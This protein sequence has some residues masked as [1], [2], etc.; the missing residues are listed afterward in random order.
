[1]YLSQRYWVTLY[2]ILYISQLF[3]YHIL[4]RR[5][6]DFTKHLIFVDLVT[7]LEIF[8]LLDN[9]RPLSLTIDGRSSHLRISSS[10]N[11]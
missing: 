6:K 3:Y 4:E 1:M 8:V 11:F 7:I 9:S 5:T 10:S 2:N